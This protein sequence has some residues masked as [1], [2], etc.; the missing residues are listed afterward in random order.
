MPT[1]ELI[2]PKSYNHLGRIWKQGEVVEIT[3]ELAAELEDNPR[4]RIRG[5][6]AARGARATSGKP[7]GRD[8]LIRRSATSPTGSIPTMRRIT[9]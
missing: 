4:F 9:R 5:F 7:K 3:D 1:A 8:E 2:K 6:G